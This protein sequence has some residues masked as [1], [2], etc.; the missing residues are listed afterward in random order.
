MAIYEG[1]PQSGLQEFA[2]Q[3]GPV[4][5]LYCRAPIAG[6]FR[7][8]WI[9]SSGALIFGASAAVHHYNFSSRAVAVFINRLF[10]LPLVNYFDD[11]GSIAP[12]SLSGDGLRVLIDVCALFGCHP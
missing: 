5:I 1:Q 6:R 12:A 8:V 10:G 2:T 11:I 3:P 7:L 9:R 4:A